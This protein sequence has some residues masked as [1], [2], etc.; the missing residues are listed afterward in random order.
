VGTVTYY[1]PGLESHR[2]SYMLHITTGENIIRLIYSDYKI[3][4][5]HCQ[6][7]HEIKE[8]SIERSAVRDSVQEELNKVKQ[9]AQEFRYESSYIRLTHSNSQ[10]Y[11]I[12]FNP[13]VLLIFPPTFN[14]FRAL[15]FSLFWFRNPRHSQIT[16]VHYRQL[17]SMPQ[18]SS[19]IIWIGE[20]ARIVA[21][22]IIVIFDLC[23]A[24]IVDPQGKFVT[25]SKIFQSF[26]LASEA[27]YLVSISPPLLAPVSPE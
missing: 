20:A 9:Y 22:L 26:H 17:L 25:A 12:S 14:I 24:S 1:E 10:F 15:D 13:A 5:F 11:F 19:S 3:N 8:C 4:P 21:P 27:G 7:S 23:K 6:L 2:V 18:E 16:I